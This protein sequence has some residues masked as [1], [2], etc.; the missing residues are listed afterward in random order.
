MD[1]I[2]SGKRISNW[3]IFGVLSSNS[4]KSLNDCW[5]SGIERYFTDCDRIFANNTRW[6][7]SNRKC[8]TQEVSFHNVQWYLNVS[9][10]DIS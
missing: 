9:K 1:W 2:K 4:T 6:L 7:C 5:V 10:W 8:I 3:R